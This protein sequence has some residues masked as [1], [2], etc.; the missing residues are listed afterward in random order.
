MCTASSTAFYVG[1]DDPNSGPHAYVASAL[2]TELSVSDGFS[3]CLCFMSQHATLTT[4]RGHW[5]WECQHLIGWE[6]RT[7]ELSPQIPCSGLD[8]AYAI[9]LY[10]P[11]TTV[12]TKT[13]WQKCEV[14][15]RIGSSIGKQK[16]RLVLTSLP[17][18]SSVQGPQSMEQCHPHLGWV[19]PPPI[20]VNPVYKLTIGPVVCF[21]GDSKGHQDG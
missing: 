11:I 21:H 7:G 18:F 14:A 13:Q 1:V 6:E 12:V 16:W 20:L 17:L 3:Y 10:M 9:C 5:Q 15:G 4:P 2:L 8:M 19:F